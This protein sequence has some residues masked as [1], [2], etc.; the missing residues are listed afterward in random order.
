MNT[1]GLAQINTT[2][3]YLKVWCMA[4]KLKRAAKTSGVS[5]MKIG[6]AQK[7]Q[8]IFKWPQIP[9]GRQTCHVRGLFSFDS[10]LQTWSLS[11]LSTSAT[12]RE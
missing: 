2:Y 4:P 12:S 9:V 8:G 5:N 11:A 6:W 10:N 7:V 3:C 1:P